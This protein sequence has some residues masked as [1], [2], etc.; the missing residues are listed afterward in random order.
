MEAKMKPA[1]LDDA[2]L[3]P[4]EVMSC[5]RMI[6]VHAVRDNGFSP[7]DVSELLGISRSSVYAWLK[8]FKSVSRIDQKYSRS[9]LFGSGFA[10]LGQCD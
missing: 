10:G 8:R 2:R 6:A 1:W 3:I 7:E 5:L 9:A 4:D